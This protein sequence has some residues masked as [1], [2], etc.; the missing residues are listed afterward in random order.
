[1]C[2]FS[3]RLA[4]RDEVELDPALA[5]SGV[6]DVARELAPVVDADHR[7]L[8]V[9]LDEPLRA[10]TT[11]DPGSEWSTSMTD[12]ALGGRRRLRSPRAAW[13]PG[14]IQEKPPPELF[15]P[16]PDYDVA[17]PSFTD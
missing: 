9:R 12:E 17:D 3:G 1:M 16:G 11:R 7:G 8:A 5:G 2:A 10:R 14:D 13:L 15:E 6:D 4:A